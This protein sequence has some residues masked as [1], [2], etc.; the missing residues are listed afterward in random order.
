MSEHAASKLL[1]SYQT[2]PFRYSDAALCEVRGEVVI[3]G[4]TDARIPWPLGKLP[5]GRGRGLVVF[6]GLAAA[7]R[8]ESASAICAWWGVTPQTVTKYRKALGV[9]PMTPG[10]ARLKSHSAK[11][12]PGIAEALRLAQAKAADPERRRKIAESRRGKSRPQHVIEAMRRGRVGKPQSAEARRKMS[13]SQTTRLRPPPVAWDAGHHALLGE[14]PDAEVARRTG[15]S[16]KAVASR[17]TR[18]GIDSPSA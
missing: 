18:L 7:L 16:E 2:P 4:L 8:V 6:A 9:G 15:R 14:V 17:R 10:T 5:G 11:D 3:T 12:S 1:G 13:A